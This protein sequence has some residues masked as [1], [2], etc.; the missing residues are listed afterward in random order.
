MNNKNVILI[1]VDAVRSYKT[2][3]DEK[4]R[5]NIYDNLTDQGFISL[6]KLVVSAPSSLMSSIT[7]L[8]GIPS[9][10]LGQTYTDFKWEPDLYDVVPDLL[11]K[12]GYEIFGLFGTKEM[13]DR[14]KGI[15]PPIKK[16]LTSK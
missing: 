4:D 6:D 8:T 15:F 12:N 11:S 1:V 7:M 10:A 13:R 9:Y 5:L 3:K 14:M 2:G 16:K